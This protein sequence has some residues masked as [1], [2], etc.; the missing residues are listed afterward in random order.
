MNTAKKRRGRPRKGS[1]EAK[2]ESLLLR[3]EP[4]E[5]QAFGDAAR[6][7][8]VPLTVWIRE[9]C[10]KVAL[11]ELTDAG[12]PVGFVQKNLG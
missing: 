9:R 5:K 6:V 11:R 7:A 4:G 8:G 1:G 3:L 2:S 10:R 12:L